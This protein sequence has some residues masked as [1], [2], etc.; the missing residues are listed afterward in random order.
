MTIDEHE[1]TPARP[2]LWRRFFGLF[3]PGDGPPLRDVVT[4]AGWYPLVI[5]T[6]LNVVDELDRAVL[7]VFAPNLRRYFGINNTAIGAIVGAQLGLIIVAAVPVGY[8]ATRVDRARLLRWSAAIWGVFS[9][10]TTFAITLPS[11]VAT[12][13]GAS[14]GKASVEPVGKAFLADQYPPT[15][16]N[17]VFAIHNAANPLGAIIGPL[18]AGGLGL[19]ITG[20]DIW[21]WAFPVLTVPT[22]IALVAA[23]RLRETDT[24]VAKDVLGATITATGA[25]KG[26]GFV[27]SVRKLVRIPTFRRQ[28][29]GIG[30]LGFGLVGIIAFGSIFY[31]DV[32]GVGEAGRGAIFTILGVA[33]LAGTLLGGTVGERLFQQSPARCVRLVGGGIAAFSVVIAG[34]VFIPSLPVT[35]VVQWFAVVAVSIA[36]APLAAILSAI[37]PPILRP[38]M[39]SLLGLCIALFGGVLGGVFVGAIADA[40]NIQIALATLAPFGIVGGLLMSRGAETVDADIAAA[41]GGVPGPTPASPV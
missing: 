34:S 19:F 6:T 4:S 12:R 28:L 41:A 38:L 30:V 39:F 13:L 27:R 5:L 21:R 32:H 2:T 9:T 17:R 15:G 22:F 3:L 16:W 10:A 14:I 7:G 35:V 25:P 33:N 37:S 24:H 29:V 8:W 31:E 36:G 23:R 18:I 11:F 20:D 40:A 26:E 1:A